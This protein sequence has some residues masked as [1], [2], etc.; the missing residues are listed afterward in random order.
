MPWHAIVADARLDRRNDLLRDR[1]V[2]ITRGKNSCVHLRLLRTV[3]ASDHSGAPACEGAGFRTLLPRRRWSERRPARARSLRRG[4]FANLRSSKAFEPV[5][6]SV[7]IRGYG[8]R[9]P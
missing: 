5:G 3:G 2:G 9:S 6:G 4:S 8:L 7:G 1:L